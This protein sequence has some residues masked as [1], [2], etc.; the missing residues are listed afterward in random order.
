MTFT[1]ILFLH[2]TPFQMG[3]LNA[4]QILPAFISGLLAGAWVD[5][6]HRRPLIIVA[7]IGRA[8]VLASIPLAAFL[9]ILRIGQ[10]YLVAL[11]TSVL[12]IFFDVAY[13]SY[14]PSL[15]GKESL[16]EGNSKLS[17]SSAVAEFVGFSIAGWLVQLLTAPLT[18]LVDAG[19]F[20]VSAFSV[21]R[22]RT[23]EPPIVTEEQPNL[24]REI[25]EGLKAVWSQP[26]L[27]A[28]G[29]VILIQSLAGG[30]Y[31]AVVVLYMS[32][33][34]GFDP[35]VLGMIWAVGGI[36][37]L[38]GAT[39]APRATQRFGAGRVMAA[40]LLIFAFASLF[41]PLSRGAT[42][43]SMIFMIMAQLGDGFFVAYDINNLSFRQNVVDPRLL[44]RVNATMRFLTLGA[45]LV[46]S[47]LGGGLG[48]WAGM[49]P[50]MFLG[51]FGTFLAVLVLGFSPL[52]KLKEV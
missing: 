39:L 30:I 22:I 8:I 41:V 7:D 40:G 31:G 49:R 13:Q 5:R 9:G 50:T 2:A 35:G 52:S 12:G 14:L 11:A 42:L 48:E 20:L 17:A 16:M 32:Q 36:S 23:P 38:V 34:L 37:S 43:L 21:W 28:S 15:V 10:V 3:L 46:G 33:G 18:I 45:T 25:I 24:R 29:L 51:V 27:R 6:L 1:A 26:L 4:M 44:G 47:L 19:S